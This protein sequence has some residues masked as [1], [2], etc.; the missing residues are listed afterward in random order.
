MKNPDGQKCSR[1][2]NA[3]VLY[4]SFKKGWREE[5][6]SFIFLLTVFLKIKVIL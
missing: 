2:E 5:T 3:S 6:E 1:P 4:E